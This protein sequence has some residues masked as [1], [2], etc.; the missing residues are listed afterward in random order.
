MTTAPADV[1]EEA[2]WDWSD[3]R[4]VCLH[5][6]RRV[7]GASS[8]VEDAAQEAAIRAWRRRHTCRAPRHAGPWVAAIA[9]HE[10]VRVAAR[11]IDHDLGRGAEQSTTPVDV[12]GTLDVR[13]A[14]MALN[15]SDRLLLVG[16]YWQDLSHGE[17]ARQL[18][19]AESTVRVRLHRLRRRLRETLV[20]E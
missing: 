8:A 16:R 6:A 20:E 7:L 9:R 11:P 13:G 14:M 5:E 12:A 1:P 4:A 17:L 18:G 10:A 2:D 15:M 3:V 19:L